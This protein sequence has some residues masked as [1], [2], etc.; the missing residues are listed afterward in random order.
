M[1]D[2]G[3]SIGLYLGMSVMSCVEF[4]E[5][6]IDLLIYFIIWCYVRLRGGYVEVNSVQYIHMFYSLCFKERVPIIITTFWIK[7]AVCFHWFVII[8]YIMKFRLN[9]ILSKDNMRLKGSV[10]FPPSRGVTHFLD[11]VEAQFHRHLD[12]NFWVRSFNVDIMLILPCRCDRMLKQ[13][14]PTN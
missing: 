5:L 6:F 13:R 4:I 2:I 1:S 14:W 11:E 12:S 8:I 9:M 7:L 3:G 10:K